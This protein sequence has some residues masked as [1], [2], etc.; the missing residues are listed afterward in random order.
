MATIRKELRLARAPADVWDA[1]RDVGAIHNRVARGFVLDTKVDDGARMVTFAN[2][3]V[4]RELI[5]T[6]DDAARRLAYAV[7]GSPN[8]THHNASFQVLED[9]AGA[10]IIWIADILPDAAAAAIGGMMDAGVQAMRATL[11]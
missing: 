5:V 3:F 8:L 9:G 2:G 6:I 1:F 7:V 10:R 11:G 4:A